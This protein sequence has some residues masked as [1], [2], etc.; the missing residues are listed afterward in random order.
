MFNTLV[1]PLDKDHVLRSIT[2]GWEYIVSVSSGIFKGYFIYENELDVRT[3]CFDGYSSVMPDLYGGVVC[4]FYSDDDRLSFTYD[5]K[6]RLIRK[7][8]VASRIAYDVLERHTSNELSDRLSIKK[9]SAVK[10][11]VLQTVVLPVD[12]EHSLVQTWSGMWRYVS[13]LSSKTYVIYRTEFIHKDNKIYISLF[14]RKMKVYEGDKLSVCWTKDI[15]RYL[16]TREKE[17][18]FADS[19]SL[20]IDRAFLIDRRGWGRFMYF[21]DSDM[22]IHAFLLD[23]NDETR[24]DLP[25]IF[26]AGNACTGYE[27]VVL[28]Q[29][30]YDEYMQDS[31][32]D[33]AL[34]GKVYAAVRLAH[35]TMESPFFNQKGLIREYVKKVSE[36]RA[37]LY[38]IMNTI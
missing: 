15:L 16:V 3:Y 6:K 4:N 35:P 18:H 37:S 5:D 1:L 8:Y 28:K 33:F 30:S 19:V 11:Q 13:K 24:E 26:D 20:R 7:E 36:K 21:L 38:D 27:T 2:D 32:G 9:K 22:L 10:K 17:K 23:D 12:D 29:D 34:T 31:T 14:D 25:W